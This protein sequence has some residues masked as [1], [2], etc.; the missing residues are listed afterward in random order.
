MP[1]AEEDVVLC[2]GLGLFS[3]RGLGRGWYLSIGR[4]DVAHLAQRGDF[5][6]YFVGERDGGEDGEVAGCEAHC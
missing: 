1:G 5:G 4:A 2:V 3:R 6:F